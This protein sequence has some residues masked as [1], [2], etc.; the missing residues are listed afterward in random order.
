MGHGL[1]KGVGYLREYDNYLSTDKSNNLLLAHSYSCILRNT[2]DS[3]RV[4]NKKFKSDWF[5]TFL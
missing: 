4:Q 3:L 2:G 1:Y 5:V